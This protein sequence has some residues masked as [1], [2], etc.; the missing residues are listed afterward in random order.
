MTT[1]PQSPASQLRD[2]IAMLASAT[3]SFHACGTMERCADAEVVSLLTASGE[4]LRAAES[5]MITATGE[6]QQ[7]SA[8]ADVA[9]RLTTRLGC[10]SVAEAIQQTTLVS[11]GTARKLTRVAQA[12]APGRSISS[13]SALPP[14]LPA[15][16]AALHDTAVGLDG[17]I[18]VTAALQPR[19]RTLDSEFVAIADQALAAAARGEDFDP[20]TGETRPDATMPAT[21]DVLRIHATAWA[22]AIDPDGAEPIEQ[23]ALRKRGVT[24]GR[25]RDGLVE[26]HGL[27]MAEGAEQMQRFFDA[28]GTPRHTR[29]SFSDPAHQPGHCSCEDKSA[30]RCADDGVADTRTAT[31][32]RHDALVMAF[33][34]AAGSEDAPLLGGAAPTL[35]IMVDETALAAGSGTAHLPAT[36]ATVPLAAAHHAACAGTTQRVTLNEGRVTHIS[37][38]QRI[39]TIHQ[40]RAITLRDGGCVIPGCEIPAAWCEIHHVE[41]HARGGPTHTD[42][43][44][45]LCWFHHRYLEISGWSIRMRDGVPEVRAPGWIDPTGRWRSNTRSSLRLTRRAHR[46]KPAGGRGTREPRANEANAAPDG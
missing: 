31:Q 24:L 7:R 8:T 15:L 6:V 26:L 44:V 40:R 20:A 34:L 2:A 5:L 29:V 32:K 12:V 3:R 37:S 43:G 1:T 28:V 18:V 42:N 14:A 38:P 33:T 41:E 45:L 10:G 23:A 39:F 17:A 25:V 36:G 27:I 16:R 35:L 22:S 4:A 9:E 11:S 13:G 46:V 30:C 19:G 21:A